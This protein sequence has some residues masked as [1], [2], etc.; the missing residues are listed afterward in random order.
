MGYFLGC[1]GCG[2]RTPSENCDRVCPERASIDGREA[3]V[4]AMVVK[5]FRWEEIE[6]L[7]MNFE[8]VIGVG[9]YSMV[10]LAKFPDSTLGAVKIYNSS[11]GSTKCSRMSWRFVKSYI[12]HTLSSFLAIV[13]KEMK[14]C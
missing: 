4:A 1:F 11:E 2:S 7:T 5:R 14:E 3:P 10:Y 8:E 6:R 12:M 9:G 13:M